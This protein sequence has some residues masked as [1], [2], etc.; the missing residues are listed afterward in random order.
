[1]TQPLEHRGRH[2]RVEQRLSRRQPADGAD[3]VGSA[4]LLEQIAGRTLELVQIHGRPAGEIL[5]LAAAARLVVIGARGLGGCTGL[6]LGSVSRTVLHHATCP[7]AVIPA[8][9]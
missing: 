7:V 2:R 5:D 8:G 4:H 1:M 6:A 9:I 3:Q